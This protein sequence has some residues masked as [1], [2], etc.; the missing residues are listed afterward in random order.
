MDS[1]RSLTA[2]VVTRQRA[3]QAP[4]VWLESR[5]GAPASSRSR[6]VLSLLRTSARVR[7]YTV[8]RLV[9]PSSSR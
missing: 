9:F 5:T 8:C 7:P 2:S 6:A 3:S 1:L 4:T